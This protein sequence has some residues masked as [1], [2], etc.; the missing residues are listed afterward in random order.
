MPAGL[1]WT[2]NAFFV[3]LAGFTLARASSRR[4]SGWRPL[5]AFCRARRI[6]CGGPGSQRAGPRPV[7]RLPAR[8]AVAPD[9]PRYAPP[10]VNG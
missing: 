1:F 5:S 7:L 4:A 6:R 8:A 3:G 9:A 2:G 10:G